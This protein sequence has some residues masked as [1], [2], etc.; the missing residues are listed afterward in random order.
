MQPMSEKKKKNPM[1]DSAIND[2]VI[3]DFWS[4]STEKKIKEKEL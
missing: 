3:S 4:M 2:G 1:S